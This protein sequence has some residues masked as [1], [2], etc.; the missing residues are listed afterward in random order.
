MCHATFSTP[1]QA[2]G[3]VKTL[4][5]GDKE[6]V[7]VTDIGNLL[8]RYIWIPF[9]GNCLYSNFDLF[10]YSLACCCQDGRP[11]PG[12][13]CDFEVGAWMEPPQRKI[14]F[15]KREEIPASFVSVG[16]GYQFCSPDV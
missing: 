1:Q 3:H 13:V 12:K 9:C 15:T 11:V 10:E 5:K 16:P 6:S 14:V 7:D 8:E 2:Y 4:H